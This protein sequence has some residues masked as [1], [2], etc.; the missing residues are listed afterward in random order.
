MDMMWV[1]QR[2][3][4]PESLTP[5]SHVSHILSH[6]LMSELDLPPLMRRF[7]VPWVWEVQVTQN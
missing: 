5:S 1:N 7:K 2:V 3:L 6:F 4:F